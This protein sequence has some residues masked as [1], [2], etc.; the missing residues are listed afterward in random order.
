MTGISGVG[1][2]AQ[3]IRAHAAVAH[4][5]PLGGLHHSAGEISQEQT[6]ARSSEFKAQ[7]AL[8]LKA[9]RTD[10]PLRRRKAFRIFLES[11]LADLMGNEAPADPAFQGLIDRVDLAMDSD[12]GLAAEM[13]R[14]ADFL[15]GRSSN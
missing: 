7:A 2:I 11:T 9:I 14:A 4:E 15:L 5:K 8:R 10:D 12:P 6:Q 1:K 3:A 13:N